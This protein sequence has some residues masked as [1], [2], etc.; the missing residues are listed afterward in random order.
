MHVR[1]PLPNGDPFRPAPCKKPQ[2]LAVTNCMPGTLGA[3]PPFVVTQI[4]VAIFVPTHYLCANAVV[5]LATRVASFAMAKAAPLDVVRLC[6]YPCNG[7][8]IHVPL[9][10]HGIREMKKERAMFN[11]IRFAIAAR[12]MPKSAAECKDQ[13]E[14]LRA[15]L[16]AELNHASNKELLLGA[17]DSS[18]TLVRE[19]AVAAAAGVAAGIA[20]ATGASLICTIGVGVGTALAGETVNVVCTPEGKVLVRRAI[21]PSTPAEPPVPPS[22]L[23]VNL[24]DTH[25]IPN[26]T[27]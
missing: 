5:L 4:A 6:M 15:R 26:T 2:G 21:E 9:C 11:R 16:D 17:L 14:R 22:T 12:L 25:G 13:A 10:T 7:A 27:L 20:V 3:R 24:G 18:A 1:G 23:T 8:C 19:T